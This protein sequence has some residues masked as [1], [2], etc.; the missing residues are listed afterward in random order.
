MGE[1]FVIEN[2]I[3]IIIFERN[4]CVFDRHSK[5]ESYNVMIECDFS[6]LCYYNI[7]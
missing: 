6:R 3:Y 2:R 4:V 1:I 5:N 7:Q